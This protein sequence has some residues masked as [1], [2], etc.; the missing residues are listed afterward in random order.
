MEKKQ[1]WVLIDLS[2]LFVLIMLVSSIYQT[3]KVHAMSYINK[4]IKLKIQTTESLVS[5]QSVGNEWWTGVAINNKKVDLG[6]EYTIEV[7]HD[8][9]IT[10][11]AAAQEMDSIPDQG[12][13]EKKIIVKNLNLTEPNRI[14]FEVPVVENRGRYTGNIAMWQFTFTIQREISFTEVIEQIFLW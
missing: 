6:N 14:S 4:P 1:K 13:E 3:G 8:E 9:E 7:N 11:I 5:N 2:I 12:L 10:L